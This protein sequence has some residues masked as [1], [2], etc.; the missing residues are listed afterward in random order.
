MSCPIIAVTNGTVP[1]VTFTGTVS[2]QP[3]FVFYGFGGAQ[4]GI[5]DRAVDA[6]FQLQQSNP[7]FSTSGYG[8]ALNCH[9]KP[10]M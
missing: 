9:S 1:R 7:A 8:Q 6:I 2:A 5:I 10:L 4:Q 3:L